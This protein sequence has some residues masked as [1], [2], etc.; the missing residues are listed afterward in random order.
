[1]TVVSSKEFISNGDKYFEL[2]LNEEIFVKRES[3]NILFIVK[4]DKKEYLEPDEDLRRAISGNE[5]KK[6]M[7][8]AINNFFAN[9]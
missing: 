2:A 5:L 8:R 1:M 7:R 4:R 3:D 9:K 6:N